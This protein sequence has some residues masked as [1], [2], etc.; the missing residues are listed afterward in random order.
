VESVQIKD[1]IKGI[2]D[3]L[4]ELEQPIEKKWSNCV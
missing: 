2:H 3:E 1:A 4:N